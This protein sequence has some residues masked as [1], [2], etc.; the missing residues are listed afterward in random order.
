[1]FEYRPMAVNDNLSI[2]S[3]TDGLW[4]NGKSQ[5][6]RRGGGLLLDEQSNIS[7]VATSYCQMSWMA[8]NLKRQVFLHL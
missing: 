3:W 6:Q 1:M 2:A 7:E 8:L 5:S 4:N